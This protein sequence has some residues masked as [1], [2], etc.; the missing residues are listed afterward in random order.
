M[1]GNDRSNDLATFVSAAAHLSAC[2]MNLTHL[3]W[4]LDRLR[5]ASPR[6]HGCHAHGCCSRMP[7]VDANWVE[8]KR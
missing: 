2:A 7:R 6:G 5:E 1:E 4:R 3:A 8:K